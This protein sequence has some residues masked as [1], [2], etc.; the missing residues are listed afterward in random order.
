MHQE[1]VSATLTFAAPAAQVFAVLA[2]PTT[3]ASID[4][5]GWVQD[6]VDRAPLTA[7]GQIFRMSMH[8]GKHPDGDYQTVNK[9]VAFDPPHAIGWTTGQEKAGGEPE[10]GGWIW[11][12]DLAP[13]GPSETGVTLTYDWSG[14]PRY[15]R[16][17]GI[18]F[19]PF[20]PDHLVN[21][22]HHLAGLAAAA[23]TPRR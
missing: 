14:V 19:P 2:D 6:A 5:T 18:P 15:I 17:R 20:A 11:R 22:L 4:G 3:H 23:A 7:A 13:L 16:D 1:T 8:F 12:Y 21:S 9:V 10:F